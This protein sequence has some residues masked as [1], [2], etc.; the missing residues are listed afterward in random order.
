MEPGQVIA[1]IETD[2]VTM[3]VEA[4][5]DGEISEIPQLP[6]GTQG[7]KVTTLDRAHERRRR[8]TG[9]QTRAES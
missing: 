6:E 7:V 5:D 9:A 4:V 2:K 1:E 3:E 8:R